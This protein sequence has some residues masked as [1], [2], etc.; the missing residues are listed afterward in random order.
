MEYSISYNMDD[1]EEDNNDHAWYLLNCYYYV[2]DADLNALPL[3]S[4]LILI[5]TL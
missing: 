1:G 4:H 5:T 2:L 3:L